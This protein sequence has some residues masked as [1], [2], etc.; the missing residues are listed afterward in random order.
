MGREGALGP[1]E[2][3]GRKIKSVFLEE[4]APEWRPEAAQKSAGRVSSSC[5]AQERGDHRWR[6]LGGQRQVEGGCGA[7]GALMGGQGALEPAQVRAGGC[8]QKL[9]VESPAGHRG[10]MQGA[11]AASEKPRLKACAASTQRRG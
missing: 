11:R 3:L 2:G 1:P 8:E 5:T 7:A 4:A 10:D 9:G 6:A